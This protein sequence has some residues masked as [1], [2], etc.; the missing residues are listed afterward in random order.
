MSE[1]KHYVLCMAMPDENHVVLIRKERP[2]WQAGRLNFPGGELKPGEIAQGAAAREYYEETGVETNPE[3]WKQFGFLFGRDW[4]VSVMKCP[5]DAKH[6]Q[7]KTQTDEE[8][9]INEIDYYIMY[10]HGLVRFVDT[11]L[12]LYRDHVTSFHIHAG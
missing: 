5:I 11:V 4:G 6:N 10:P 2:Q 3:D 7:A 12:H 9:S 1:L 8:I